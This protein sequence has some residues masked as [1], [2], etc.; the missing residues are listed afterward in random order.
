MNEIVRGLDVK[1][2]A[3]ISREEVDQ[4]NKT[5]P[6][7]ENASLTDGDEKRIADILSGEAEF[8][9]EHNIIG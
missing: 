6:L 2:T 3:T 4:Y 9:S 7:T 1:F 5:I 8:L